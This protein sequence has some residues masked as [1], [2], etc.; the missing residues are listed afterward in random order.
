MECL[1][2]GRGNVYETSTE[3]VKDSSNVRVHIHF[4]SYQR[5]ENTVHIFDDGT[6]LYIPN[7]QKRFEL[8]KWYRFDKIYP[9]TILNKEVYEN[10]G[11][12]L[13]EN[14]LKGLDTAL[15]A[16]GQSDNDRY[17]TL[18]SKDGILTHLA[19]HLFDRLSKVDASSFKVYISYVQIHNE[20]VIDLLS[21]K[22][23]SELNAKKS[24]D[25]K[26]MTW[27]TVQ[28]PSDVY[29]CI[30]CGYKSVLVNKRSLETSHL[31]LQICIEEL[32]QNES[33]FQPV[34]DPKLNIDDEISQQNK[35]DVLDEDNIRSKIRIIDLTF[36][37]RILKE[38]IL[39]QNTKEFQSVNLSLLELGNVISA[40]SSGNS[41]TH[42]P[43][44]NS[45][46]THMLCDSLERVMVLIRC[47]TQSTNMSKT[48]ASLEFGRKMKKYL[49]RLINKPY[50][51]HKN[52]Y[53]NLEEKSDLMQ[54]QQSNK[55]QDYQKVL[56]T[57]Q[58][59]K[60][61]NLSY[62]ISREEQILGRENSISKEES[63]SEEMDCELEN[64]IKMISSN[65]KII[66]SQNEKIKQLLDEHQQVQIFSAIKCET[67]ALKAKNDN[68]NKTQLSV[69][70]PFEHN[71]LNE[72]NISDKE[73]WEVFDSKQEILK[74]NPEGSL[75]YCSTFQNKG[76]T[77]QLDEC[78][79]DDNLANHNETNNIQQSE[80]LNVKKNFST[81]VFKGLSF[82][83]HIK[84][85]KKS[86][87][88]RNEVNILKSCLVV[89]LLTIHEM[90]NKKTQNQDGAN[91][92]SADNCLHKKDDIFPL[93]LKTFNQIYRILRNMI[94]ELSTNRLEEEVKLLYDMLINHE[95]MLSNQEKLVESELLKL[96]KRISTHTFYHDYE[97][98]ESI[99]DTMSKIVFSMKIDH[100]YTMDGRQILELLQF[101]H[102]IKAC[103]L[104]LVNVRKRYFPKSFLPHDPSSKVTYR[105]DKR[106]QT[107]IE[108]GIFS[109]GPTISY[110]VV[111]GTTSK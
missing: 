43:Y 42:I 48:K 74:Q 90:W 85:K 80:N 111:C 9:F 20:E 52:L 99:Y 34:D 31:I 21:P 16:Y 4:N 87:S 5:E 14:A 59:R 38:H 54:V 88:C 1:N 105:Y 101:L 15:F 39:N 100:L 104:C 53:I 86:I 12:Y 37:E 36:S 18:M 50:N 107:V 89:E 92:K 51:N 110:T 27:L 8:D 67:R 62:I 97:G 13:L 61:E 11:F 47:S 2:V 49:T 22:S 78:C 24:S 102:S 72:T 82:L 75:L 70:T 33:L 19:S 71:K 45:V 60:N 79:E 55:L 10:S 3:C 98:Y 77:V 106:R 28:S 25:D 44:R 103:L 65:E 81:N 41:K 64:L 73:M 91:T 30:E 7:K 63:R 94:A 32:K 95:A 56:K 26:T 66:T 46:M 17:E 6:Q 69:S 29:R 57:L 93:L 68:E 76:F 84:N 40:I 58:E 23:Q 96:L 35:Q 108:K 109:T 83:R